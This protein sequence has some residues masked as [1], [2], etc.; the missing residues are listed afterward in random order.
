MSPSRHLVVG[1]LMNEEEKDS[2]LLRYVELRVFL[3]KRFWKIS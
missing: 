1:F 3:N 2:P